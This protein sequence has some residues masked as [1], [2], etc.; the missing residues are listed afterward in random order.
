MIEH[1]PDLSVPVRAEHGQGASTIPAQQTSGRRAS[2]SLA[3]AEPSMPSHRPTAGQL[4]LA[5]LVALVVTAMWR[6][7]LPLSVPRCCDAKRYLTMAEDPSQ[8]APTPFAYRVLVPYLT[9]LIGGVPRLT[10]DRI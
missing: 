4:L 10:F 5:L 9:H 3:P 2:Q 7:V 1:T 8:A 6:K